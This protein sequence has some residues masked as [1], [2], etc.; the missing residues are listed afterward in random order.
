M[1]SQN[2]QIPHIQVSTLIKK[3]TLGSSHFFGGLWEVE[4][5]KH[6]WEVEAGILGI[7]CVVFFIIFE[8]NHVTL[9]LD[10][11]GV[12]HMQEL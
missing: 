6:R 3:E 1:F 7:V 2:F 8:L 12:G 11:C 5:E 10:S 4:E 9:L